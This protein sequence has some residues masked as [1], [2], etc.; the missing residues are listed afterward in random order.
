MSGSDVSWGGEWGEEEA[1]L[2]RMAR[3]SHFS[4]SGFIT[5]QNKVHEAAIWKVR[6]PAIGKYRGEGPW[7]GHVLAIF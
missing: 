3:E 5:E 1:V 2:D 6:G 4:R 7:N